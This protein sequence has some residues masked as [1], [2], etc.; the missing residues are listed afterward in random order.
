MQQHDQIGHG[1]LQKTARLLSIRK[2]VTFITFVIEKV[3]LWENY[4]FFE[5]MMNDTLIAA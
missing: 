4:M 5:I 2:C 1:D 3:F